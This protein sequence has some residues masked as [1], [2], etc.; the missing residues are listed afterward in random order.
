M[1][2]FSYLTT[3][4]RRITISTAPPIS[5]T[6]MQSGILMNI[7][8]SGALSALLEQTVRSK[9][10]V[11][12]VCSLRKAII[13]D[14]TL[15]GPS[16][17]S[18]SIPKPALAQE[19]VNRATQVL[20]YLLFCCLTSIILTYTGFISG[21]ACAQCDADNFVLNDNYECVECADVVSTLLTMIAGLM[22]F[23]CYVKYK[24][25]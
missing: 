24:V 14:W 9:A 8:V 22:L 21:T 15:P 3:W 23:L 16:F 13:L 11:W 6:M 5:P 10:Q 18:V 17:L 4:T 2:I 20:Y 1:L 7:W 12:I 19:Y 25:P